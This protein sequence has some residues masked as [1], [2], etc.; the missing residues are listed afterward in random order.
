MSGIDPFWPHT[1]RQCEVGKLLYDRCKEF[2]QDSFIQFMKVLVDC[3]KSDGSVVFFASEL[4]K[5][6][7][8][9][10]GHFKGAIKAN[11]GTHSKG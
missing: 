7:D 3:R 2:D 6:S 4:S 1:V 10:F 5:I 11:N 9:L 8:A